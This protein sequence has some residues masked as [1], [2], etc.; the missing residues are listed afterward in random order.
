MATTKF[1]DA[2]TL[3]I[4]SGVAYPHQVAQ[5]LRNAVAE[6]SK[7][8]GEPL[9]TKFK[10]N[11]IVLRDNRPVGYGYIRLTNSKVYNILCGKNTDGS[12][13]YEEYEDPDWVAPEESESTDWADM[14]DDEC[15]TIKKYLEPIVKLQ[16]YKLDD[17]QKTM[18]KDQMI[19]TAKHDGTYREGMTFEINDF[20]NFEVSSAF[21]Y[22]VE[23]NL[24]D[25]ILCARKIPTTINETMLKNFFTPYVS[26]SKTKVKRRQRGQMVQDTYP[27]VTINNERI[28]FVTFDPKTN[29]AQFA[30]LMTKKVEMN[31][32][33]KPVTLI[34]THSYKTK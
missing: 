29:D 15:P 11:L 30:L 13:R 32:A 27:F 25:N 18:L 5:S 8:L 22:Q 20:E 33:G 19:E 10:I 28:A 17:K 3:Y 9:E 23:D 14:M 12:E 1:Y 16:G 24:C 2:N 31:D 26:D 34:F 6:A 21:V 4:K 7:I